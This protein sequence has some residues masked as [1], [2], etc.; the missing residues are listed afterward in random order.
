M[1]VFNK[2][3]FGHQRRGNN[4]L[5]L[6]W[7]LLILSETDQSTTS[8]VFFNHSKKH[9]HKRQ[10]CLYVYTT[11]PKHFTPSKV[12]SKIEQ[13]IQHSWADHEQCV[14]CCRNVHD[15]EFTMRDVGVGYKLFVGYTP[16]ID[17]TIIWNP[18]LI[19]AIF[20]DLRAI[21]FKLHNALSYAVLKATQW[22]NIEW[23]VI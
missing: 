21:E 11:G 9:N 8:S 14:H 10:I 1:R 5:L 6:Y 22:L 12:Y 17:S 16:A 3:D 13:I 4:N 18:T 19:F 23:T 15:S 20:Q 7:F 2:P